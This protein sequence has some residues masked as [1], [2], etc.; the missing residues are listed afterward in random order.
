MTCHTVMRYLIVRGDITHKCII[1]MHHLSTATHTHTHHFSLHASHHAGYRGAVIRHQRVSALHVNT[2]LTLF[3]LSSDS[4][5]EHFCY[6]LSFGQTR[7]L[8]SFLYHSK[9]AHTSSHDLHPLCTHHVRIMG[10]IR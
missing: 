2:E 1:H 7:S 10:T 5:E 4:H 6:L 9:E 3:Q 8:F